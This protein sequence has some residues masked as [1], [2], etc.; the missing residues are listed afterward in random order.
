MRHGVGWASGMLGDPLP[1][2]IRWRDAHTVSA[3]S[4]GIAP[5]NAEPN[6]KFGGAQCPPYGSSFRIKAE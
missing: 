4:V 3:Y 6:N 1:P 2:D 5:R